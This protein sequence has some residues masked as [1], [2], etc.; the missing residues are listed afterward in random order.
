MAATMQP[1]TQPALRQIAVK[2]SMSRLP[3]S[4]DTCSER[5]QF[6]RYI[7]IV[8]TREPEPSGGRMT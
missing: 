6:F 4:A 1:L 7:R 3:R 5:D 2:S 8:T